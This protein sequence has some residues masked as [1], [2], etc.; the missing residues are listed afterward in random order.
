MNIVSHCPVSNRAKCESH[1]ISQKKQGKLTGRGNS[2][3]QTNRGAHRCILRDRKGVVGF[4]EEG[5]R[6]VALQDVH[7]DVSRINS[8]HASSVLSRDRQLHIAA[9]QLGK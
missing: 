8:R 1:N 7:G 5:R 3:N 2:L 4:L 6:L 9:A